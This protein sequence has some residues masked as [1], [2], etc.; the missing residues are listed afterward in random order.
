MEEGY[1]EAQINNIYRLRHLWER[2][3]Y[4]P[5]QR[6]DVTD[7]IQLE[8]DALDKEEK[9]LFDIR[10]NRWP[11]DMYLAQEI[12]LRTN[13]HDAE[14]NKHRGEDSEA[15]TTLWAFFSSLYPVRAKNFYS[16]KAATN[17]SDGMQTENV[18]EA[19]PLDING[20]ITGQQLPY[21]ISQSKRTR[22]RLAR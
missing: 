11:K 13:L 14:L 5:C 20:S 16:K 21:Q 8:L 9:F 22:E 4:R 18:Y 1:E 17:S 3:K 15:L 10:N 2:N 12:L 6:S 7:Q 19:T